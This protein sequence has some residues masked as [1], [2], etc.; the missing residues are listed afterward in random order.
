MSSRSVRF[1]LG[2]PADRSEIATACACGRP[3]SFSLRIFALMTALDFPGFKGI[4][5][6]NGRSRSLTGKRE[7][8]LNDTQILT[9]T[10]SIVI[11]LAMLLYSNTRITD[12]KD[13]LRAE[14]AELRSEMRHGFERIELLLKMHEAEHHQK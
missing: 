8:H 9:L 10:L 5:R 1:G 2:L 14:M 13:T 4:S 7:S 12:V 6:Y 3:S 11:P